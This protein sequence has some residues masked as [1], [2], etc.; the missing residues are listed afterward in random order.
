MLCV[1]AIMAI[2]G[3]NKMKGN[4]FSEDLVRC[5]GKKFEFVKLGMM[6]EYDG[7][8]GTIVGLNHAANFIVKMSNQ[9]K[10]KKKIICHPVYK[11]KYFDE[12]GNVIKSFD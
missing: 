12:K 3:V 6:I 5:R 4:R 11:I 9:L 1:L 2:N 7:E 8:P 10:Y